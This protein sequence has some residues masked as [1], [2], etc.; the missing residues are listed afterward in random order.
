MS[1]EQSHK[2]ALLYLMAAALVVAMVGAACS[3]DDDEDG[4]ASGSGEPQSGGTLRVGM[5]SDAWDFDPPNVLMMPAIAGV[6]HMYDNLV[7]RNPD[8]TLQPM[9][10]ESW[11]TNDDASQWTFHLRE[12]VKFRHGKE[13]KAEDVIFSINRLFEMESP[14][15]SVMARP[16]D[17]VAV[18]DYTLR[19]E[20]DGPNAVLLEALVKY[21]APITPS[22]VD[23]ARFLTEEFGTGPFFVAEHVTGERTVFRKNENYWWEGHPLLDEVIFI[24][25]SSAE[26]R[27]EALKAGTVDV[28]FDLDADSVPNLEADPNTL[29]LKAASSSYMNLAMDV[30]EPPFDNVLVRKALQA[31]T[32]REAILQAALFG[33]GA[34]AY[35]IPVTPSDPVFNPSCVPPDYDPELAKD[36]LAQAGYPDGIDLTLY[37]STTG[38]GA[39]VPLA[40]VM[41]EKA[42]AAG[43]NISIQSVPET[44]YW[45]DVWLQVPFSTVWWGG[46]PPYEAISVV[47]PSGVPWNESYYSNA[48]VDALLKE[49]LGTADLEEQKRIYGELQC[50]IVDEVPRIIPVF[51]PVLL[52]VREE[53]RDLLPMADATLQLHEAW[54]D[55]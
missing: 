19:L 43:F 48:K 50:I 17:M 52:G 51:R 34:I 47:Y 39:M 53:V 20:F 32:D 30:R 12:G 18:D 42:A 23:P 11:D 36:L 24:Y 28:I 15:S 27:A 10:A 45:S 4:S 55:K 7:K 29:V 16:T 25:L 41:K 8:G 6:P 9:L 21:H 1:F 49:A 5:V 2:R 13:F 44:N 22:D 33:I 3:S 26:A 54:L 31:A 35:D 14:L 46:R 38:G 40:T 37:T